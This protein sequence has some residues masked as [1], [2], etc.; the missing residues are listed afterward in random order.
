M[1]HSHPK[2]V[3]VIMALPFYGQLLFLKSIL[4]SVLKT[5]DT[6]PLLISCIRLPVWLSL[7]LLR[8]GIHASLPWIP[9]HLGHGEQQEGDASEKEEDE[10]SAGTSKGPGVVVFDPDCVLALDHAFDWLTHHLQWDEG[11]ETWEREGERCVNMS[12]TMK[13][14]W[15]FVHCKK[16][17]NA[18]GKLKYCWTH[19]QMRKTCQQVWGGSLFLCL[20]RYRTPSNTVS[21]G[22]WSQD[23]RWIWLQPRCCTLERKRP[24]VLTRC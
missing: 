24:R 9:G 6:V 10:A 7:H 4:K 17:L 19:L 5:K 11:T 3:S 20:Y 18:A 16:P 2:Q 13:A 12:L 14:K 8:L 22:S 15:G 23:W 21:P 1:V